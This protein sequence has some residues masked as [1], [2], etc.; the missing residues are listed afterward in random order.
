M[1]KSRK[2][3]GGGEGVR[4]AK[5]LLL[6]GY[7]GHSGYAYAV[8]YYLNMKGERPLILVAKGSGWVKKKLSRFGEVEELTLPR[9]PGE[10]LVRTLH[11][12]F[13]CLGESL[14]KIPGRLE[15]I[16]ATGSNFSLIPA[17]VARVKGVRV[18]NLESIDRILEASRATKIISRF[19]HATFLHWPEQMKNYPEG[20]V[21]GPVYEPAT[22]K[23][24]DGG[25]VLV[26]AGTLGNKE[27][28]D[29][30]LKSSWERVVLQTGEVD[31]EPYARARPDWRVFRFTHDFDR[32]LAGAR[33][34]VTQFPGMTG[35]TAALAYKKPVVLVP[36]RHVPMSSSLENAPLFAEKIGAVY[37]D[38]ISPRILEEAVEKALK[39][40]PPS[41]PNGAEK[42]ASILLESS[43]DHRDS[44]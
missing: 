20:I 22:V 33:V 21:V 28:F 14:L 17:L 2:R 15:A 39:N 36:G 23:P 10:P 34:V 42:I 29:A 6:A 16:L 7:G 3:R 24:Y 18:Y 43:M 11:R 9:R 12:W 35:A 44:S 37:V 1:E 31:P 40:T 19:A 13:L 27:L 5:T 30:V 25:Y 41:Y 38:R 32:V 4:L 26:T 8:A